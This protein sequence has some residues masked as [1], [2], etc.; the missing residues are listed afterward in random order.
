MCV[1]EYNV[2]AAWV[3]PGCY[4]NEVGCKS[5]VAEPAKPERGW[6]GIRRHIVGLPGVRDRIHITRFF[7]GALR[8]VNQRRTTE[9]L[10]PGKVRKHG[11]AKFDGSAVCVTAP[12]AWPPLARRSALK[13][14][15]SVSR[16]AIK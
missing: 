4:L 10:I 14:G 3:R 5:L 6:L 12:T 13:G 8:G 2:V 15:A 16:A 11:G 9:A 7:N 1:A